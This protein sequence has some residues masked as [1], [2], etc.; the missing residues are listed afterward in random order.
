MS[1]RRPDTPIERVLGAV[2][3]G[4]VMVIGGV[5]TH[6]MHHETFTNVEAG[7]WLLLGVIVGAIDF[8][9]DFRR[10]AKP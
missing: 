6:H 8:H 1:A 5:I 4:T 9:H 10:K 3:S 2:V 7:A